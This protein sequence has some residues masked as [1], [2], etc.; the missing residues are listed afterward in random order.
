MFKLLNAIGKD[1]WMHFTLSLILM[2]LIYA[3]LSAVGLGAYAIIPA[4]VVTMAV[5]VIKEFKDKKE[6]GLFDHHDIVADFLGCFIAIVIASLL[7]I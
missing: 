1:K 3:V 2:Q 5:G 6:T 4:L 7:L